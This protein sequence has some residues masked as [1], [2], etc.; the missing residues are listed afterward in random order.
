LPWC[1][2]NSP[3]CTDRSAAHAAVRNRSGLWVSRAAFEL[4]GWRSRP[5]V[6]LPELDG[7][8]DIAFRSEVAAT[9][10]TPG[11]KAQP[12]AREVGHSAKV[13]VA[14][15]GVRLAVV[16][17]VRLGV[18]GRSAHGSR[19]SGPLLGHLSALREASAHRRTRDLNWELTT[20]PRY[21]AEQMRR[22]DGPGPDRAV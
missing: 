14:G 2:A 22:C 15:G 13:G 5:A 1:A 9:W 7:R 3:L 16:T 20:D 11:K 17:R 4:S 10:V 6:R 21:G 18:V 19:L 8:L 12:P